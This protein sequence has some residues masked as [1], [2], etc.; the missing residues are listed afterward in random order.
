[1]SLQ[2]CFSKQMNKPALVLKNQII[3]PFF[4]DYFSSEISTVFNSLTNNI[5]QYI[6][7]GDTC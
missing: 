5:Y 4:K 1:M 2:F 6:Q 7:L 3:L